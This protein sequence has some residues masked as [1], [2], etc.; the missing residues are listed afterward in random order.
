MHFRRRRLPK[1]PPTVSILRASSCGSTTCCTSSTVHSPGLKD[2][3]VPN[4]NLAYHFK[5]YFNT[6]IVAV[7]MFLACRS[8]QFPVFRAFKTQALTMA[9]RSHGETNEQLVGNLAKHGVVHHSRVRDA[10]LAVDRAQFTVEKEDAYLDCP[11]VSVISSWRARRTR[12]PVGTTS[13]P[14]QSSARMLLS[15]AAHRPRRNHIGPAH[16]CSRIGAAG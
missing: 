3:Q 7:L 15:A 1:R 9:W 6:V 11:Q 14:R 10:L 16:A 13:T 8:G 5:V 2:A 4:S 12:Q